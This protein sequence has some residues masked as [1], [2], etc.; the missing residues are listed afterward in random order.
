MSETHAEIHTGEMISGICFKMPHGEGERREEG[1][2]SETDNTKM[3]KYWQL[4]RLGHKYVKYVN[5]IFV[6]CK[7]P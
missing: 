1:L 5:F 4:V 7:F 3:A 6:C 2:Q